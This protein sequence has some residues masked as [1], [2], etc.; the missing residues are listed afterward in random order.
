M[1]PSLR[2]NLKRIGQSIMP[3]AHGI[4]Q[5]LRI[6]VLVLALFY[7]FVIAF[8]SYFFFKSANISSRYN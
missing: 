5:A 6:H 3:Y 1:M 7:G 8:L 2:Y 4:W